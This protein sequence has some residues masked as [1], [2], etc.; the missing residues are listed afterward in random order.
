MI[1]Q[2]NLNFHDEYYPSVGEDSDNE[3]NL[4]VDK[5]KNCPF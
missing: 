2:R 5:I 3:N 1:L 4:L